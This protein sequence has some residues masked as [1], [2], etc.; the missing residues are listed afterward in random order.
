MLLVRSRPWLNL[1]DGGN[2]SSVDE[3]GV[4]GFAVWENVTLEKAVDVVEGVTQGR[5][6]CVRDD[7]LMGMCSVMSSRCCRRVTDAPPLER[8]LGRGASI[9]EGLDGRESGCGNSV[10]VKAE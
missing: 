2:A 4:S 6:C 7:V 9:D 1:M 5:D 8:V 3:R 10:R